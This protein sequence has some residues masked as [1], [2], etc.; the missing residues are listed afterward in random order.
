VVCVEGAKMGVMDSKI[1]TQL[2]SGSPRLAAQWQDTMATQTDDL[3]D[4][5]DAGIVD[6]KIAKSD[7]A[8]EIGNFVDERSRSR[9]VI[10]LTLPQR[11]VRHAP[12]VPVLR[13]ARLENT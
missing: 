12:T 13:D 10:P 4:M 1:I 6:A 5:L 11:T 3:Q 7:L 8:M 9:S 2:L